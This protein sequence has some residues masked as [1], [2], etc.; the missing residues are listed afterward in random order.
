LRRSRILFIRGRRLR[1]EFTP[2][3]ATYALADGDPL[4]ILITARR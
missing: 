1:V 4:E 2:A 3:E